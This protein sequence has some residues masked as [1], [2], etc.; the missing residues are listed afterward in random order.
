MVKRVSL[1]FIA[2]CIG[3]F[4]GPAYADDQALVQEASP[5]ARGGSFG[6]YANAGV[7]ASWLTGP[8]GTGLLGSYTEYSSPGFSIEVGLAII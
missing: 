2:C 3:P 5:G 4:A 7:G 8:A 6:P 1:L